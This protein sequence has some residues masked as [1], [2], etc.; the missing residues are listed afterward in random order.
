MDRLAKLCTVS[1]GVLLLSSMLAFAPRTMTA[2]ETLWSRTHGA[3]PVPSFARRY[4]LSCSTCHTVFPALNEYGELFRAK[5]YKLPGSGGTLEGEE[6]LA[7]GPEGNSEGAR[8]A[9]QIP[10]IDIPATSVAGFQVLT[11]FRYRNDAEVT[12][13]FT[14]ISSVGLIFGGNMGERFS[15]FGN[16]ALVENGKFEG[17]DRLFLQYNPSLGFNVRVGQF[18]PRAI[19]FSNHRRLLRVTPYLNGV[20]PII[21]AQNFFGF[22][23]NQKGVELFGRFAGPGG[24]GDLQ[25][26]VGLINGEPGGAFEALEGGHGPAAELT[27]VL[28]EAYEEH[29]GDFDFNNQKDYYARL[30]YLTWLRGTF[31][32]GGFLYKGTSG[33]LM[34]TEDPESFVRDGNDFD[35]WGLDVRWDQENG[36]LALLGSV[37]F[38]NDH[39]TRTQMAEPSA[40][41]DTGEVQFYF[42]PWLVP[43]FRI[44]RVTVDGFPQGF[45]TSF[46]RYSVDV[47]A[48]LGSN[49]MLM[50]G[51]TWSS[52]SA[53]DLPLFENFA[54]V[55]L[56]LAF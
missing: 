36:Y 1:L 37:Q 21:P 7:L 50:A 19:P 54:R 6:P 55:S 26:A 31:S 25:Y 29:G 9:S 35:R 44:E 2:Y 16:V 49:I 33:F 34:D 10:F 4:N 3:V 5:G 42:S 32:I 14:G 12:N 11:D 39:L 46:Q 47:L 40:R 30:N 8:P 53:P 41:I 23:P 56:H 17:I 45:P 20:F 48:L 51:P 43:G 15:F 28:E 27:H 38:F 52:G 13:E 24:R 18:E 22:S